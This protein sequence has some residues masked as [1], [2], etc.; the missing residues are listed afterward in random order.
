MKRLLALLAPLVLS[1]PALAHEDHSHHMAPMT[2]AAVKTSSAKVSIADVALVDQDGRSR[3]LRSDVMGERIVVVDFIYTTCTTICPVISATF[4]QVQRALGDTLG[5]DVTLVSLSVDPAR[6]TPA[7]MKAYGEK[8][9]AKADWVWLTGAPNVVNGVLKGLGAY[10]ADPAAH[11]P[12][13][14]VGDARTGQWTRFFD[15]PPAAQILAKVDELR[16]ARAPADPKTARARDYFTDTVLKTHRGENVRFYT[17]V[18]KDHVVL[19]N[20]M[21]AECGDACPMIT[22]T[23]NQVR[24]ELGAQFGRDVR[25]VSLSVDPKRDTPGDMARY[26][27]KFGAEHPEWLFITGEVPA[28]E[29]VLKK[30]GGYTPD[31]AD[32][33]TAMIIGNARADRWRKVRPDA[34]PAVI[35]AEL[36]SI[37]GEPLASA[38]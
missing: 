38:N 25:F 33:T 16:A 24:R 31:P 10:V 18:L 20:F 14:L 12:M 36:R 27:K 5:K 28:M 19:M 30:L 9:A 22:H 21:Y 29:A 3:K 26:A 17:D 13:I 35:A 11:P 23:M 6:D 8:F 2:P 4:G 34:P 1:L 7:A 32:H 15:F 37:L